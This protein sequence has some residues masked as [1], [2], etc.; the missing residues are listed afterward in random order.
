[1]SVINDMLRDLETRMAP[2]RQAPAGLPRSLVAQKPQMSKWLL[3]LCAVMILAIVTSL[4][5]LLKPSGVSGAAVE[6]DAVASFPPTT[7]DSVADIDGSI[8]EQE[9][10]VSATL[11]DAAPRETH[12]PVTAQ[13]KPVSEITSAEES[14]LVAVPPE[15][16]RI[17]KTDLSAAG[18]SPA[19]SEEAAHVVQEKP[20][21]TQ[22]VAE[23]KVAVSKP[24]NE[25]PSVI[26]ATVAEATDGPK[27]A[28]V[29]LTPQARDQANAL[30][31][32]DTLKKGHDQKVV[33]S[34]YRFIS[35]NEV[36]G[37]SRAVL[38]RHMLSQQRLEAAGDLLAAVDGRS[39]V[40]LREL[41]ARWYAAHGM[42]D[43]ALKTLNSARPDVRENP[44]YYA[45]MA[46]YYQQE[47]Q[48]P[49]AVDTYS[50]LL[51]QNSDVADW[52][53]G[54]AIGLDQMQRYNDAVL[55]YRQA[56]ALP[57]L[58]SSLASFSQSRLQKLT[59]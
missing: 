48:F 3:L 32:A 24:K 38:A 42:L 49:E 27:S 28:G 29:V 40:P 16:A 21:S 36:D 22:R 12:Q 30:Q 19:M 6:I 10:V 41:K 59:L 20:S 2:E 4:W 46:S 26:E 1:M 44:E 5:F 53:V 7:T 54:M 55:A 14:A 58:K 31:A 8:H 9:Q 11:Q 45:L 43:A 34:L 25:N 51:E 15:S 50:L 39:I 23:Q 33:D 57:N 35:E 37:L 17:S 47:G 13:S 56:L 18:Q 52:W